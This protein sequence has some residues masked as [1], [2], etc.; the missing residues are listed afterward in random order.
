MSPD[1]YPNDGE[2]VTQGVY[3]AEEDKGQ[4]RRVIEERQLI[5]TTLPIFKDLIDWFDKQVEWAGSIQRVDL[6]AKLPPEAQILA[7]QE[8]QRILSEKRGELMTL[9]SVNLSILHD[10]EEA[11]DDDGEDEAA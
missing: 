1:D 2:A 10:D 11:T 4:T 6:D 7:F 3:V 9:Q 5:Q 8:I